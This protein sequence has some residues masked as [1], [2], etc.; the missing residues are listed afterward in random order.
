[1]MVV[2]FKM[3]HTKRLSKL[4]RSIIFIRIVSDYVHMSR[5]IRHTLDFIVN[6]NNVVLAAC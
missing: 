4:K 1:M 2:P 5:M 3:A 6:E